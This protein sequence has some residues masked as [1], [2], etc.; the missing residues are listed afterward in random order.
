MILISSI[1]VYIFLEGRHEI[2]GCQKTEGA[3]YQLHR[4]TESAV[5]F[6]DGRRPWTDRNSNKVF[7]KY[8]LA[9]PSSRTVKV[10]Y[11]SYAG[12]WKPWSQRWNW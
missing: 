8:E 12:A 1:T 11:Q 2:R 4:P 9:A 7:T 5:R 10:R 6:M 3:K